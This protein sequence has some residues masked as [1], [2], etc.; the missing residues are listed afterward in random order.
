MDEGGGGGMAG[1]GGAGA[2]WVGAKGALL[3]GGRL[4]TTLRDDLGHI[5]FPGHWDLVGGGREGGES[6]RE[7]LIRE[8][9]EEVGLDLG[10]AEWLW[11]SRFPSMADPSRPSWFFVLRMPPAAARAIAL[12]DEG[13][14]WML[15]PPARFL[16]L[17]RA[18]P[19][20]QARLAAWLGR[21]GASPGTS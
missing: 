20:L 15:I 4:L 14:G 10:T 19:A 21:L 1:P 8:A 13:Q 6:P 17:P 9:R 7:T 16:A 2:G 11:Q 3:L 18:V 12:G 5:P